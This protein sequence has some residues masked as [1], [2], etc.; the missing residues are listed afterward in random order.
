VN[1]TLYGTTQEGGTGS[2]KNGCGTVFSVDA[3]TGSDT[4]L[5]SF[6]DAEQTYLG[7]GALLATG[8]TLFGTTQGGGRRNE[9][10]LYSLD[11]QSGAFKK[12][13]YFCNLFDCSDGA[14]PNSGLLAIQGTIYGTAGGGGAHNG[15]VVFSLDATT[16]AETVLYS[17]C[18]RQNCADAGDP[19]AGLLSV[20]GTLYGTTQDGP[21]A[22]CDPLY[23]S[24]GAVFSFDPAT[25]TES[26]IYAFCS[27]QNCTDGQRPEGALIN[28]NEVLYG[29]TY[30]G[31]T[32]NIGTVFSIDLS[33]GTQTVLHSFAY[34][35][36]GE[37]PLGSLLRVKG[38]LFGTT[39][40]G[41]KYRSGTVFSIDLKTGKEKIVHSFC[42]QTNCA[43]GAW[44]E[45][46][47]LNVNGTLYGVTYHG[48]SGTCTAPNEPSGCGAVFSITP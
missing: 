40:F 7:P 41:G 38:K 47:L 15:G 30:Y 27:Q 26:V 28:V 18:S 19:G 10:M 23:Y 37:N 31:G 8:G 12:Q 4:V 5:H 44:P 43:D 34:K 22:Y 9:G 2:C 29:T 14:G 21:G 25:G 17:F 48:G 36:D 45:A 35:H 42:S 20:N 32:D 24:C 13:Y 11:A 16:G 46:G 39:V 33:T 1:G 6:S 3:A